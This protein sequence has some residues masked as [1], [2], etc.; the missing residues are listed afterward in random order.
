MPAL[1]EHLTLDDLAGAAGTVMVVGRVGLPI[2]VVQSRL[3][4]Q[5]TAAEQQPATFL[6][7]NE[8]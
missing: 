3:Q 8:G 2:H 6:I 1:S 4:Y 5:R 7:I